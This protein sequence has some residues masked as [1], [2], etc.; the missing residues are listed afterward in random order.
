MQQNAVKYTVSE[1]QGSI[2]K[3]WDNGYI[4]QCCITR[5]YHRISNIRHLKTVES[6]MH[7]IFSPPVT[8]CKEHAIIE[9]NILLIQTELNYHLQEQIGTINACTRTSFELIS[10]PLHGMQL[11]THLDQSLSK[12]KRVQF[13]VQNIRSQ[14][15]KTL[16]GTL[17]V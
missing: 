17:L 2:I 3:R 12:S 13:S 16:D 8:A 5:F 10:V 1:L 6:K 11:A 7:L 9:I 15:A 14:I 4:I